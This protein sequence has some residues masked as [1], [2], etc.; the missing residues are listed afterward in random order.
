MSSLDGLDLKLVR[1]LVGSDATSPEGSFRAPIRSIA[2]TL[3]VDENTVR[4][5]IMRWRKTGYLRGWRVATNPALSG[6][7][8]FQAWLDVHPESRKTETIERVAAVDEVGGIKD[9]FGESICVTLYCA[10]EKGLAKTLRQIS[11]I[12]NSEKVVCVR[13]AFPECA[14]CLSGTDWNI[15][16]SLQRD[17]WRSFV[18]AGKDLGISTRTVRRRVSR[19]TEAYAVFMMADINL[20]VVKGAHFADLLVL[21]QDSEAGRRV[22]ERLAVRLDEITVFEEPGPN[23]DL[24]ALQLDNISNVKEILH[25]VR[26]ENGVSDA[27]LDLLEDVILLRDARDVRLGTELKQDVVLPTYG[28]RKASFNI[29]MNRRSSSRRSNLSAG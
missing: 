6:L 25:W 1:A 24:F 29:K 12:C 11:R 3:G 5:R 19:M 16:A 21:Y 26:T 13:S 27:R 4:S 8:M 15:I 23:H 17:P 9:Y 2:K 20:K 7:Q 10:N 28:R 22:Q 18:S 14:L